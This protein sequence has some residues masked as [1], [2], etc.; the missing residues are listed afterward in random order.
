MTD[1]DSTLTCGELESA[2]ADA[3]L[4]ISAPEAAGIMHGLVAGGLA[5]QPESWQQIWQQ[6]LNDGESLGEALEAILNR[7]LAA[8]LKDYSADSFSI[9]LLLP[10]EED[11]LADRARALGEWCQ[12]YLLGFGLLPATGKLS[13]DA[14]EAMADLA[15]ISKIDFEVE[16]DDSLENAFCMV[17]E[18]V[19]MAAQIIFTDSQAEPPAT[20]PQV[21][22]NEILH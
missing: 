7:M 1:L 8:T 18:H 13:G 17:A 4:S 15:E 6:H 16:D 10:D 14:E 2:L 20:A 19:K 11:A 12:G 9:E 5:R 3:G 21:P 22:D